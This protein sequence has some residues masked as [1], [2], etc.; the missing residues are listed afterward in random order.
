MIGTRSARSTLTDY[1]AL[2]KPPIILLLLITAMGGMLLA[3]QGLPPLRLILLVLVGGAL[4]AGGASSINHVL[5]RDLD[6]RM[7]R[8]RQSPIPSD[9][10]RPWA[11]VLFRLA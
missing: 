9:R 7:A 5:D 10:T 4:A 3:A 8:T 1:L 6:G 2:T 11:A